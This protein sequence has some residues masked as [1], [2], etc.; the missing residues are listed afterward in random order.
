[1]RMDERDSAEK[2]QQKTGMGFGHLSMNEVPP[3]ARVAAEDAP[4][5]AS[6][7]GL[8]VILVLIAAGAIVFGAKM[9]ANVAPGQEAE[10]RLR[11]QLEM[12]PAWQKGDI[13]RAEYKTGSTLRLEFSSRL[14]TAN[15]TDREAIRQVTKDVF[16]VLRKERPDRDLY[17]EG[18]QGQEQIVRGEYRYKSNLVG[19]GGQQVPDM[20][21]RVKGDAEGGVQGAYSNSAGQR[22]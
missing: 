9:I 15:D 20:T 6:R 17:I 21:M 22:R 8:L 7:A 13:M 4:K 12:L 1:M 16:D 14:D 19:P 5:P 2:G 11:R 3:S 10:A 18:F